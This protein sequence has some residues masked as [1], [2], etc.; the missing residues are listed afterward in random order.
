MQKTNF[1]GKEK[2]VLTI[3]CGLAQ[4]RKGVCQSQSHTSVKNNWQ[5]WFYV[6]LQEELQYSNSQISIFE[7]KNT[8]IRLIPGDN[9]ILINSNFCFPCSK[10]AKAR[11]RLKPEKE[12]KLGNGKKV[13]TPEIT[14]K[15]NKRK[16]DPNKRD[17][18][19]WSRM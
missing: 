16:R 18:K 17:G 13:G 11:K 15:D 3:T 9:E 4:R 19:G 6:L 7:E 2:T 8:H 1:L 12:G 10:K 14:K 5:H